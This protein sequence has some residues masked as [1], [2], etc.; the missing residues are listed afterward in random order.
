MAVKWTEEQQKVIDYRDRNIL[1]S[2]AAGSGKTAVLVERI[3]HRILE[4]EKPVDIDRMLVV[5]FTKAAAAEMRERI[6]K[7]IETKR[8]LANEKN[9]TD[10][11]LEKQAS[12]IHNAQITTIDAFCLFVVRNHFEEINLDPDFRI[13]DSGEVTLLENEVIAD[14]FESNYTRED[15]EAFLRLIDSYSSGRNDNA[16][17]DMVLKIYHE[18]ESASWPL[19]WIEGLSRIY[20]VEN[21]EEL[22]QTDMIKNITDYVLMMMGEYRDQLVSL[23]ERAKSVAGLEK[24][25]MTLENDKAL[26]EPLDDINDFA[27][28]KEFFDKFKMPAIAAIRG[29]DGDEAAKESIKNARN[30]IKDGINSIIKAYFTVDIPE[31]TEQIKR[32]AETVDELV[33]LSCEYN[34]LMEVKKREK[35]IAT[36]SDIEHFALRILVD[37]ESMERTETAIQFSKHFE[38]IMIDEYQ[39]SNQVQEDIMTAISR[40]ADGQ[41]N[42]F[43]V[44][45]V[46]QSIYRFRQAKPELFMSKYNSFELEESKNQ[47]IDLHKNFRS[48]KEVIDFCNDIFYKIMAPDLGR[49]SYDKDSALYCGAQFEETDGMEP[50]LILADLKDEGLSG[51]LQD[52]DS[53]AVRIEA[54]MTARRIQDLVAKGA[55]YSDIVILARSLSSW[56][57]EFADVLKD[58]GIPAHVTSQMGYFSAY[59]VQIVLAMLKIL[60]NPCQD[61]PMAAVLK[62]P[63]VG[64]DDEELA[65]L[66]VEN[67]DGAFSKALAGIL[68]KQE[69]EKQDNQ[70][71]DKE[72]TESK[73]DEKDITELSP[74]LQKFV[75]TYRELRAAIS[76]TPIHTLIEQL[77]DKTGFGDYVAAMPSGKRRQQNLEMLFEMAVN[78]ESTSYKGLFHFVKYIETL[79]KYEV[80]F[81]EAET[82]SENDDVVRIMTI[83]KSKGLEFPI[84]F[85]SGMGRKMNQRDTQD[86]LVLHPEQGLG[87]TEM[88]KKPRARIKRNT[89]IRSEIARQLKYENLG[90]ELRVLYV[91]LTRAKEKIILTGTVKDYGKTISKYTADTKPMKPISFGQRAQAQTYLDWILPAVL[92]YPDKY[93][94]TLKSG[95]D[96]AVREAKELASFEIDRDTLMKN[97][98]QVEPDTVEDISKHFDFEYKYKSDAARKSK[99]SV[100]EIKHD[101]MLQKYDSEKGEAQKPDFLIEE[102]ESYIPSFISEKENDGRGVSQGALRG[103]AVHRVMECLD[104]AGLYDA[105]KTVQ[106]DHDYDY[107][108]DSIR[109]FVEKELARMLSQGL[110]D[111]DMNELINPD[112]IC[113]FAGS[114]TAYRMAEADK[115][116]LLFREKPFVM[117]YDGALLQGI[118]DAFWIEEGRVIVL[119]YK[120]DKVKKAEELILRYKTQLDI[121]ADALARIFD[122]DKS[123][124]LIYSFRLQEIIEIE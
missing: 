79:Q 122:T 88:L 76:D 21:E 13:A 24:Y 121:Y 123:E 103:T 29:F 113:K 119:D 100:S 95:M 30:A 82:I 11:N 84:V 51:T 44:G 78:Y 73:E 86:T 25:V 85:V 47:R 97:I 15:N 66:R 62:S 3:I 61:I 58:C 35:R 96:M 50:E 64:L 75:D 4:D 77:L 7:A 112:L 71:Q 56:G 38:E 87:L 37:E 93:D 10:E 117:D 20:H 99:Y 41:N 69:N 92:S 104:F 70:E 80:D 39:D 22:L 19:K 109:E 114:H 28:L 12:L 43:M 27:S 60:D 91:A 1:V 57:A 45:D 72:N 120:T 68:Q 2:A 83:H 53:K 65:E 106:N 116:K 107:G 115:N 52:E 33:R 32:Q 102:R 63:I 54:L 42:M 67:K 14:L 46:K 81:G 34:R 59:E 48:R 108:A 118:I 90:E 124:E 26:M 16:V 105:L 9:E 5:T 98:L 55:K 49:V 101:S 111:E 8:Q 89:L 40:C 110:I 18:A 94:I 23:T 31:I 6:A 17:R 74:A 36:F